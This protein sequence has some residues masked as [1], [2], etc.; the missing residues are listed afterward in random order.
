MSSSFTLQDFDLEVAV[1]FI[2]FYYMAL[3]IMR[4]CQLAGRTCFGTKCTVERYGKGTWALVTGGTAGLG[5]AAVLELASRGF[6]IIIVANEPY[7]MG[8]I[9]QEINKAYP[10]I[11]VEKYEFDFGRNVEIKDF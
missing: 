5:R 9:E 8:Q 6:N 3:W 10:K 1:F 7:K 11:K 4:Y 2:G